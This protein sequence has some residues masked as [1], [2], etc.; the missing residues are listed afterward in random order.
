MK[1]ETR[2]PEDPVPAPIFS[3]PK[4]GIVSVLGF[5]PHIPNSFLNLLCSVALLQLEVELDQGFPC[6]AAP[7]AST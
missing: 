2:P 1:P 6:R 3:N 5:G 7:D 4:H